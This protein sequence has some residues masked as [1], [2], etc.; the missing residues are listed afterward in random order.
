MQYDT[1]IGVSQSGIDSISLMGSV[2][3]GCG[4][5]SDRMLKGYNCPQILPLFHWV[6]SK[7]EFSITS[8]TV[9]LASGLSKASGMLNS[10]LNSGSGSNKAQCPSVDPQPLL[11]AAFCVG[12]ANEQLAEGMQLHANTLASPALLAWHQAL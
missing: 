9:Q 4:S 6:G 7:L 12:L 1:R 2:V 5:W 8:V 3:S 10:A 11:S